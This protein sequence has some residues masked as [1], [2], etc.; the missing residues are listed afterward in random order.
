MVLD[1]TWDSGART[2]GCPDLRRQLR[3]S[4]KVAGGAP[5]IHGMMRRSTF[6]DTPAVP[7]VEMPP[8]LN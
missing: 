5:L 7:E 2:P 6:V 1:S 3:L 8:P 4:V